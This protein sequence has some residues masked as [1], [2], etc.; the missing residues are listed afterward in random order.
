MLSR[1]VVGAPPNEVSVRRL[2][3]VAVAGSLALA[4]CPKDEPVATPPPPAES[5]SPSPSP[6]PTPDPVVGI[7]NVTSTSV[8]NGPVVFNPGD[9]DSIPAEADQPAIDG[10]A[11]AVAVWLDAHLDD[12]QNGGPG[13][14]AEVAAPGMLDLASPDAVA[15][16]TTGL[17]SPDHFVDSATY[18]IAVFHD[19]PPQW[20][21]AT[22]DVTWRDGGSARASF[23]FVPERQLVALEP[24]PVQPPPPAGSEAGTDAATEPTEAS[25]S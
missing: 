17:A 24:P 23:L 19:G 4:A 13:A 9:D 3:V 6:T 5:P 8:S 21:H 12:L 2:V 25:S 20:L 22:A 11:E 7:R 10:F 14:L 1:A 15:A 16:V 18:T